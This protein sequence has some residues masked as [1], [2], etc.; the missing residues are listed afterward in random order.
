MVVFVV[1]TYQKKLESKNEVPS[2]LHVVHYVSDDKDVSSIPYFCLE[3]ST[4]SS[5]S[6]VK[7]EITEILIEDF[8]QVRGRTIVKFLE[9]LFAI[10][11]ETFISITEKF[12]K[13]EE[14]YQIV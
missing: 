9:S 14:Y 10:S 12:I 6:I 3:N 11:S 8:Q 7:K 5:P 4:N 2:Y 13:K 1:E